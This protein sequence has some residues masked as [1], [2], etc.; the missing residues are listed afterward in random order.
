MNTI[1]LLLSITSIVI[2]IFTMR[3]NYKQNKLFNERMYI[4]RQQ[5]SKRTEQHKKQGDG[6]IP[7]GQPQHFENKEGFAL[8]TSGVRVYNTKFGPSPDEKIAEIRFL[9]GLDIN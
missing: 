2:T 6:F 9:N 5:E 1:I 4:L 3:M 8:D 7:V